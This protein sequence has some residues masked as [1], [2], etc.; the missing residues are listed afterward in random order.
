MGLHHGRQAHNQA[1]GA[2]LQGKH[3]IGVLYYLLARMVLQ[4]RGSVTPTQQWDVMVDLFFYRYHSA[5]PST[6]GRPCG[7]ARSVPQTWACREALGVSGGVG[8]FREHWR[9]GGGAEGSPSTWSSETH[10][11]LGIN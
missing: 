8:R 10:E 2:V 6:R 4:M 7:C 3:S 5:H 11:I 9:K 1:L